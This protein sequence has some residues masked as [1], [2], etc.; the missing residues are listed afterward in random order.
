MTDVLYLA[1]RY[2]TY[3]RWKTFILVTSIMLI[4]YLPVGLDVLV[5][6]SAAQL[7]SRAESTPLLV[8]AARNPCCCSFVT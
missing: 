8:G 4:V 1:W 2:L 6:Q 5:D 7:T 3:N